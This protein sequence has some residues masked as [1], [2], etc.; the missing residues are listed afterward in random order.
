[1]TAQYLTLAEVAALLR[2]HQTT[3]YRLLRKKELPAFKV[4]RDWR[5]SAERIDQW[6]TELEMKQREINAARTAD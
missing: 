2:V 6:R 3:I 5:F 1:M 4:G